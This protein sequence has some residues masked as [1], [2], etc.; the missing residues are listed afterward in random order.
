MSQD[1]MEDSSQVS[2]FLQI[3]VAHPLTRENIVAAVDKA[4]AA[5]RVI[6]TFHSAPG[7]PTLPQVHG[8]AAEA[9]T[10]SYGTGDNSGSGLLMFVRS[11]GPG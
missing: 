4:L 2:K 3:E 9:H 6:P 1:P 11:E 7:S 8:Q 10:A 5:Q